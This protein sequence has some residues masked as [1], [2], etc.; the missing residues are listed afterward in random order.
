VARPGSLL[1]FLPSPTLN[2]Y[3]LLAAVVA[4]CE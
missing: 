2:T 1:P 4:T 3:P